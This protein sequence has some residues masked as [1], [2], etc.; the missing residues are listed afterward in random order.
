MKKFLA[1]LTL[2]TLFS[3]AAMAE[4]DGRFEINNNMEYEDSVAMIQSEILYMAEND[5]EI[6][7][8]LSISDDE[9]FKAN[10]TLFC[11][12]IGKSSKII[13]FFKR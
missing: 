12:D 3:S 1:V 8:L 2:A 7:M 10:Y 5:K 9:L 4:C 13:Y 6:D 11:T